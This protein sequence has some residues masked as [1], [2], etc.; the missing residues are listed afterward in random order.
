MLLWQDENVKTNKRALRAGGKSLDNIE[1]F[2]QYRSY[3]KYIVCALLV[4]VRKIR[5]IGVL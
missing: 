4:F 3:P 5:K 2:W 1:R